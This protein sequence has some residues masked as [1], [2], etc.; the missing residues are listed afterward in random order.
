M[1][2]CFL[3]KKVTYTLLFFH[4]VCDP[5][6][7]NNHKCTSLSMIFFALRLVHPTCTGS[8]ESFHGINIKFLGTYFKG[9]LVGMQ[10]KAWELGPTLF[11]P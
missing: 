10:G 6:L 4:D 3:E 9:S 8:R 7:M 2:L 11:P 1:L 5:L